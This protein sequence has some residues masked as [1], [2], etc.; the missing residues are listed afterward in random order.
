MIERLRKAMEHV[1]D[2]PEVDQEQLADIIEEMCEAKQL[3]PFDPADMPYEQG[4]FD[5]EMAD[6]D[7]IRGKLQVN[8]RSE[9]A[10][11]H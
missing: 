3:P 5:A 1:N 10:V 4:D 8:K 2:L 6:L 7:R 11:S 9:D